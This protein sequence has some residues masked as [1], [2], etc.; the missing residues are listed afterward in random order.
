MLNGATQMTQDEVDLIYE[1]LHENYEYQDGELFSKRK[2]RVIGHISE[3]G[4]MSL[5]LNKKILGRIILISIA[6]CVFI[7][8][9]KKCPKYIKHINNNPMDNK[10]EN[11]A[12]IN[13]RN[14][15]LYNPKTRGV[16]KSRN[17]YR[18]ILSIGNGKAKHIRS[19]DLEKDAECFYQ[20]VTSLIN[21]GEGLES[22]IQ[23]SLLKFPT[24]NIKKRKYPIG[25]HPVNKRFA[26]A[27]YAN[28]KK[29]YIGTYDTPEEAYEEYLKAKNEN[30]S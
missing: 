9:F 2:N 23:S 26:C 6:K 13:N 22:A 11:L 7:Y 29:I 1:Y 14:T 27:M 16:S 21:S 15:T 19:W 25:V 12:E 28:R 24:N 10:I 3:D 4:R 5:T 18:V 30:T 17:K 20:N 8:H